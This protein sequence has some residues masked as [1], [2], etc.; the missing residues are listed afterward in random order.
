ME[1]I[2]D[3]GADYAITDDIYLRLLYI[4]GETLDGKVKE[5]RDKMMEICEKGLSFNPRNRDLLEYKGWLLMMDN[6]IKESALFKTN[7]KENQH[8]LSDRTPL[9]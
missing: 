2:G 7:L 4:E 3:N 9:L 5:D 8:R 1:K 6:Q